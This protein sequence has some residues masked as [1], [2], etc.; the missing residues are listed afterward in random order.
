MICSGI[1]FEAAIFFQTNIL[2]MLYN[3]HEDCIHRGV[4]MDRKM[5]AGAS[6]RK[7]IFCIGPVS[8]P[9]EP[10]MTHLSR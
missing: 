1:L 3:I 10:V 5:G 9:V 6:F 8:I 4:R 2:S 7:W